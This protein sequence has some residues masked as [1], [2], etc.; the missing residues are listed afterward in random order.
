MTCNIENT[1]HE[2]D[3][4][5]LQITVL[6]LYVIERF[7]GLNVGRADKILTNRTRGLYIHINRIDE[8]DSFIE[9]VMY[10]PVAVE[11]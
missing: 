10:H 1:K 5:N 6:T 3:G 7:I 9:N 2:E 8:F 4:T 11:D